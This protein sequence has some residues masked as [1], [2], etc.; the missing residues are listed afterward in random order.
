[1]S[2]AERFSTATGTGKSPRSRFNPRP[3]RSATRRIEPSSG[4]PLVPGGRRSAAISLRR[5]AVSSSTRRVQGDHFDFDLGIDH[6]RGLH[7]R[8]GRQ[9][10]CEVARVHTVESL[11]IARIV[12]PYVHLDDVLQRAAG[13]FEEGANA[14]DT[15]V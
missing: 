8:P 4:N 2:S 15:V 3:V 13:L 10:L 6:E 12:Q 14:Y 11:E 7:A 9:G 1:M 5:T